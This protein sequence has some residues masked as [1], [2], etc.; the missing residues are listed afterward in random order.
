MC[1]ARDSFENNDHHTV[2]IITSAIFNTCI[3][4]LKIKLTNLNKKFLDKLENAYG[5][6]KTNYFKHISYFIENKNYLNDEIPSLMILLVNAKKLRDYTECYKKMKV[7]SSKYIR[8]Q[9][10]M[11]KYKEIIEFYYNNNCYKN[12]ELII[13]LYKKDPK[14]N[15]IFKNLK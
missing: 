12:K 5:S 2:F 9:E 8:K 3:T 11:K 13:D 15:E 6:A 1:I 4:R 7:V 10:S 14:D